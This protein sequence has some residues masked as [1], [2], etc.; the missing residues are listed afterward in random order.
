MSAKLKGLKNQFFVAQTIVERFGGDEEDL[1]QM[2][3]KVTGKKLSDLIKIEKFFPD[4]GTRFSSQKTYETL[5]YKKLASLVK[6][7]EKGD[8]HEDEIREFFKISPRINSPKIMSK[9]DIETLA[10]ACPALV[11]R[12]V[13]KAILSNNMDELYKYVNRADEINK[14]LESVWNK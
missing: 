2:F 8:A 11:V 7:C 9:Q 13:A 5:D 10:M 4:L 1:I 12:D 3:G 14:V 6:R